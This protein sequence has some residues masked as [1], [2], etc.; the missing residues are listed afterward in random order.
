[1]QAG[2]KKILCRMTQKASGQHNPEVKSMKSFLLGAAGYPMLELCWRGRTHVSMALAGGLSAELLHRTSRV[3]A[4]LLAKALLCGAGITGIEAACGLLWNRRHQVWDYRRV[5]LNW[6]G[7]VCLPYTLL[8]CSLS[9]LWLM[10]EKQLTSAS[11]TA[12]TA[13]VP[14]PQQ[15]APIDKPPLLPG[16]RS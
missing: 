5:P 12:Q 10:A 9:A 16:E 1:M 4:P 2:W 11:C 6:R 15:P 13:A 14:H 7:Q 3:H 8:W